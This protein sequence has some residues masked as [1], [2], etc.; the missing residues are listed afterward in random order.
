MRLLLAISQDLDRP[1]K[2]PG[3][4]GLYIYVYKYGNYNFFVSYDSQTDRPAHQGRSGLMPPSLWVF[5]ALTVRSRLM[6][7]TGTIFAGPNAVEADH[8]SSRRA[9]DAA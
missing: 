9:G 6:Q 3:I 1:A 2:T 5:A 8:G 4:H 7:A